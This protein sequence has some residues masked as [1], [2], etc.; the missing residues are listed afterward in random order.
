MP[1]PI[2][3]SFVIPLH[4][5]GERL[6]PLVEAFR[7]EASSMRDPWELVLVDDGSRDG[8][9]AE[10]RRLLMKFSAPVTIVALARN[11]GEHAAVLEGWRHSAGRYVVNLDD[12]LQNPVPEAR[13]LLEHLRASG[14]EVAYSYFSR[15]HHSWF[16]NLG[17]RLLN[18]SAS[19][20]L[21]KPRAL[22]LSSFRAVRRELIERIIPHRAPFPHLD[23]LILGATDR[24]TRLE[25]DHLPRHGGKSG[26]TLPGLVQLALGLLFGF[27]LVPVRIASILAL[28]LF[29]AGVLT[30]AGFAPEAESGEDRIGAFS[31]LASGLALFSGAQLVF[32]G[33]IAEYAGRAFLT[34]S[35]R[36]QSLVRDVFVNGEVAP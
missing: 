22:Y 30:L 6:L 28:T 7:S 8:T 18:E 13:R 33:V 5:T 36:S 2:E 29:G 32:L 26:Y 15:K 1:A 19:L 11:F 9:A 25:V 35:G 27:S 4:N 16:R 12:D 31:I 17:S 20:I 3:F 24:F 34:M 10:A 14:A 23:G 21:G